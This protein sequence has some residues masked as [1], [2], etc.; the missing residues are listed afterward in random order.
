VNARDYDPAQLRAWSPGPPDPA[1]WA[2]RQETHAVLVAEEDGQMAGFAE[3]EPDGHV[4][5]FYNHRDCQ[6]RGGGR[7][8][9]EALEAHARE[10]GLE[11]M[12]VEASITA[13]PFFEA[14][15]FMLLAEQKVEVRG[16]RLTN[17]RMEKRLSS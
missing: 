2:A 11:R 15:G 7:L 5:C 6:R 4:D 3:L 9:H 13:R 17:Y 8:L 16:E 1:R 14:M 12:H 10:P